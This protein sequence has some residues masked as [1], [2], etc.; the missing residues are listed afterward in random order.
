MA[1]ID[2]ILTELAEIRAVQEEHS[3]ELRG[4]SIRMGGSYKSG[5][6]L[7]TIARNILAAVTRRS[8]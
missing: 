3:K 4:F 1:D 6:N 8:Q 7:T 2:K 5:D